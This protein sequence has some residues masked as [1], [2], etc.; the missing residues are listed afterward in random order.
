MTTITINNY[1]T[2][3][4][5]VTELAESI[6]NA[7]DAGMGFGSQIHIA[8]VKFHNAIFDQI[9]KVKPANIV[10]EVLEECYQDGKYAMLMTVSTKLDA[11]G[12]PGAYDKGMDLLERSE[13]THQTVVKFVQEVVAGGK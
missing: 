10:K 3:K 2:A 7:L 1:E 11:M 4:S 12:Y 8:A 13:P 9:E 5:D 6:N